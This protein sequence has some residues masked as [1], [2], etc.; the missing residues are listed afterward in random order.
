MILTT[1]QT[2]IL[3]AILRG[4]PDGSWLDLDQ[5][6]EKLPYKTT[7]GSMQFSIRALVKHAL[8]DKKP[9]E[10]RRGQSRVVFAPTGRAYDMRMRS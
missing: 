5:L 7:K 1:K 8:I 10:L 2:Q 9:L 3:D 4:N 6:L